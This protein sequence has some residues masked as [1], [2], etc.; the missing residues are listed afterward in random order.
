MK[1]L[2][3]TTNPGKIREIDHEF[4]TAGLD[5]QILGLKDLPP[6]L[7]DCIEDQPTFL[8]NA[9]KKARHFAALSGLLTLADDSG[10]CVDALHGAP[11]VLS[12]RYA[13]E[14][15][16]NANNNA[17]LL[18]EMKSIPDE[19]RSA[20]FTCA[21]ALALQAPGSAGGPNNS[22][23]ALDLHALQ[24]HIQGQILHAPRG[25]HGFGYDPLF[26]HPPLGKTTA[27]L[28][29]PQKSAISHRGKALR[30]MIA[31]LQLHLPQL[32][33]QSG[34]PIT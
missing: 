1:L 34:V 11:G 20:H 8:T 21:M 14:P 25:T 30:R 12:A 7:P 9:A 16:N 13:G 19:K 28:D 3:A 4:H 27:E 29:M 18:H 23:A 10:L 22:P 15:C 31:W 5:L 2:I 26:L 33:A 17:K 24:D 6:N 32:A